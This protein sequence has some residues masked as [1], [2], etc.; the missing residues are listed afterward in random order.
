MKRQSLI[1]RST[2]HLVTVDLY[3]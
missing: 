3:V 2:N 1:L